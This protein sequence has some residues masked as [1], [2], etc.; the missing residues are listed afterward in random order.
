MSAILGD[1]GQ[2]A[3]FL[4]SAKGAATARVIAQQ[5]YDND[6]TLADFELGLGGELFPAVE[7]ELQRLIDI[8]DRSERVA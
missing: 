7:R 6:D 1:R 3:A 5:I 8:R 4:N 2:V